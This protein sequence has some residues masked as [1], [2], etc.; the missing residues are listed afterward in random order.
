MKRAVVL[1]LAGVLLFV[2]GCV[3]EPSKPNLKVQINECKLIG[4]KEAGFAVYEQVFVKN[5]GGKGEAAVEGFFA[6]TKGV[7]LNDSKGITVS[8]GGSELVEFYFPANV[9]FSGVCDAKATVVLSDAD[10]EKNI[11]I[12]SFVFEAEKQAQLL[13]GLA[14]PS[15][16]DDN[17]ACTR[18]RCGKETSYSCLHDVSEGEQEGCSGASGTCMKNSC[19]SGSCVQIK[20]NNC[21]GNEKCEA[22]E[23]AVSCPVDCSS[24]LI[25]NCTAPS[26]ILPTTALAYSALNKTIASCKIMNNESKQVVLTVSAS[27][28]GWSGEDTKTIDFASGQTKTVSFKLS[29]KDVFY[30]TNEVANAKIVFKATRSGATVFEET[31]DVL[32]GA[33]GDIVWTLNETWDNSPLVVEMVTPHDA[34]VEKIISLAKEKMPGRSLAGY[35]GYE[36]LSKETAEAKTIQQAKAI[37][38]SLQD[39]GIS[40]VNTPVSFASQ[41]T[42]RVKLPWESV[43]QK[44]GNCI[45]GSLVFAS[46]FE[47]LGMNS[48]IV[49]VPGHAF[50]GVENIA[51]SGSFSFVETTMLGTNSFEEA[52]ASGNSQYNQYKGTKNIKVVNVSG[53]RAAGLVPFPSNK[54]SCTIQTVSCSDGT[55]SGSCSLTKPFYCMG[56]KLVQKASSCGCPEGKVAVGAGCVDSAITLKDETVQLPAG[57]AVFYG[58]PA[59][60]ASTASYAYFAVSNVALEV[61][62]VDSVSEYT[63]FLRGDAFNYNTECYD[64]NAFVFDKQC[65]H[66]QTGGIILGNKGSGTAEVKIKITKSRE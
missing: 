64:E 22:S 50:V 25:F 6:G 55:K 1:L 12:R 35:L 16:C 36:M 28:P 54:T 10:V 27:V 26:S 15:S 51:G 32:L 21:C 42:Q 4:S 47:D 52:L 24:N 7:K 31:K 11:P 2:S 41:E 60:T 39:V 33:K 13:I 34:C 30:S 14:C 63:K 8:D 57:Y 43:E 5:S 48:M 40:Y 38:E 37:Y 61:Y 44:S 23:D 65:A 53:A 45:D 62:V 3:F 59:D 20:T 56:G 17:N 19:S 49:L 18:D 66:A 29:F 9:S 58:D 46:V